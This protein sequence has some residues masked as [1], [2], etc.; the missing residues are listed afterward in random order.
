MRMSFWTG[1]T[2]VENSAEY[3][4]LHSFLNS[5]QICPFHGQGPHAW[6][7]SLNDTTKSAATCT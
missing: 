5:T 2:W 3:R 4:V 1:S 6:L 7:F